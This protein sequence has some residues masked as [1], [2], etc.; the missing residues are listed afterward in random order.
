MLGF[1]MEG[2]IL[3]LTSLHQESVDCISRD[4]PDTP[5]YNN[6]LKKAKNSAVINHQEFKLKILFFIF[7]RH[8]KMTD[9]Q[10]TVMMKEA[11]ATL[12]VDSASVIQLL[13][14]FHVRNA[15]CMQT[16]LLS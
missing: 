2:H 3:S 10:S 14:I 4:R 12:P 9:L 1:V 13:S 5:I 6:T 8:R 7:G 16:P 15:Q 11:G